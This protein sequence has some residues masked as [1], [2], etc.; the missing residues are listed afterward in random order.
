MYSGKSELTVDEK[1]RF[2]IPARYRPALQ[3]QC[4]GRLVV[5]I[6]VE[7]CL[8]IYPADTWKVFAERILQLAEFNP[9]AKGCLLYTSPSPRD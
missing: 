9:Q 7:P 5:T 3:E 2:A 1:G 8:L 4:A 6:D